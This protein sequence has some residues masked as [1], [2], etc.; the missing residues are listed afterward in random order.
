MTS[1]KPKNDFITGGV[2]FRAEIRKNG[3]PYQLLKGHYNT[4]AQLE[5]WMAEY[6]P[7]GQ[8]LEWEGFGDLL[9]LTVWQYWGTRL[10][11]VSMNGRKYV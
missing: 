6:W 5:C 2:Y 3:K 1:A 4:P 11:G 10:H 9:E 7:W 8:V